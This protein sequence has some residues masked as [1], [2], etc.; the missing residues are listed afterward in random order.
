MTLLVCWRDLW[1]LKPFLDLKVL[2]QRLQGMIIPSI[3][4]ASMWSF[5][6]VPPPSFPQ[7]LHRSAKTCH[8]P[9]GILFWLFSIIDFT[10][11]S[12]S[13]K[14]PWLFPWMDNLL[15]SPIFW[16]FLLASATPVKCE[17]HKSWPPKSHLS[18]T[19]CCEP[20]FPGYQTI[21]CNTLEY[22]SIPYN[23]MQYQTIPH[24]TM[25]YL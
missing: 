21:P 9:F 5:M 12:S 8:I 15:C 14:S 22:I 17:W 18:F 19:V 13:S 20:G 10:F 7:T 3:W 2:S 23:T 6:A 1:V 16:I 11:L 25:Q 24:N 4:F